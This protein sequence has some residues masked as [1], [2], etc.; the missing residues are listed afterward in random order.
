M[1]AV[2]RCVEKYCEQPCK[3]FYLKISQMPEGFYVC[4][5]GYSVYHKRNNEG[6][7]FFVGMLV[8]KHYKKKSNVKT[9]DEEYMIIQEQMFFSLMHAQEEYLEIQRTLEQSKEIHKDLLHDVRKLDSLIKSKSDAIIREYGKDTNCSHELLNKIKNINAM[10]ELIACK[11]SVYDL[12][13]NIGVL[14]MGTTSLVNV[15]KKFDKV[16]YILIGYKNKKVNIEFEGETTYEYAMSI[17]YADILPF[18]LLENA[19]KYTIGDHDIT[20]TFEEKKDVLYVSITSYG[21]YCEEDE[22]EMIFN[23]NYRGRNTEKYSTEGTGVGL[24]LVK[25]ICNQFNIEIRI[26]S[27]YIK[28]FNGIKCGYFTVNLIF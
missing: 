24:F 27:D 23:R 19:I 3:K 14:T 21:P 4:P 9:K 25:E 7:K 6:S 17:G 5:S 18:L 12:V 8:K 1:Q 13:S 28:T 2:H 26:S 22:L 11:Y 16:R 20:V 15:Y 10:E